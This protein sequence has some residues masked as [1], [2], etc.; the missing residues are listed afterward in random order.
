MVV[1]C[2]MFCS[3][4]EL[5]GRPRRDK[6]FFPVTRLNSG[7]T[8]IIN[9]FPTDLGLVLLLLLM[10]TAPWRV[11]VSY[12]C[13]PPSYASSVRVLILL[14]E[15]SRAT[16]WIQMRHYF[17]GLTNHLSCHLPFRS[18]HPTF[19]VTFWS[20]PSKGSMRVAKC[21]HPSPSPTII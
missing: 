13:D 19:W 20:V 16:G 1:N 18:F 2:F 11:G 9:I 12:W 21:F 6:R 15:V 8:R 10:Q 4:G 3:W 17:W 14:L 7:K 5:W